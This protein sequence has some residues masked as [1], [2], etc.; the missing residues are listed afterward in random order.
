MLQQLPNRQPDVL[1]DF[2]QQDWR[3]ISPVMER[4]GRSPAVRM[5]ELFVTTSLSR[6]A[7]PE[8]FE[9]GHNLCRFEDGHITHG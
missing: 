7:E 2:S 6:F 8:A 9:D 4:Y 1:R 3:D 5:S